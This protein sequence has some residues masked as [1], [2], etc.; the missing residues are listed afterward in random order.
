MSRKGIPDREWKVLL[1][2]SGNRCAFSGCPHRLV[3]DATESDPGAFLAEAAHIVADSRQGPRGRVPLTPEERNQ[4]NNLLL[5]CREHHKLIDSQPRTF[6]VPVLRQMKIDHE[7]RMSAATQAPEQPSTLKLSKEVVHSSALAVE[8]FPNYVYVARS[9]FGDEERGE[10]RRAVK[11]RGF[12]NILLPYAIE[13][14]QFYAFY[15]LRAR[16]NPFAA[17]MKGRPH[18]IEVSELISSPGGAHVLTLLL[19]RSLHRFAGPLRIKYDHDHHR[20]Y[21]ACN[22]RH[23]ERSVTYRSLTDRKQTRLVAWRPTSK[24]TNEKRN[25]WWHLAAGLKFARV[26]NDEWC[27]TIRPERHITKNGE[28]PYPAKYVGRKVT[29]H[30]S[31]MFNPNY[32]SEVHFWRTVL[33]DG[34]SDIVLDFGAQSLIINSSL[35]TFTVTWPLITDDPPVSKVRLDSGE[36]EE[37]A[38]GDRVPQG[39]ELPVEED[40][41]N[42]EQDLEGA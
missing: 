39:D 38:Y 22:A 14:G 17:L 12:D 4:A 42:P 2:R 25:F 28:D 16:K 18:A 37:A 32:L 23:K 31:R 40:A 10:A 36:L 5:L 41:P 11:Y 20:F 6:S 9:A 35:I 26:G 3:A 34:Y 29:S 19:N 1:L 27:L 24:A 8:E 21:F 7:Q 33:S 13:G 30:K 15:D